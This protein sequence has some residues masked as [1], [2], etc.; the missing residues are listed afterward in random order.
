MV[1]EYN[2]L[3]HYK[4]IKFFGGQKGFNYLQSRDK[5]KE[6]YCLDN[7]IKLLVISY[8]DDIENKLKTLNI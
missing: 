2:G 7:N 5:V 4:P 6:Q 1:I 8:K 3:Q